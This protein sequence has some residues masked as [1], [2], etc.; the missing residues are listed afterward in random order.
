MWSSLKRTL[1]DF[2][3]GVD[4]AHAVWHG[5]PVKPRRRKHDESAAQAAEAAR[6]ADRRTPRRDIEQ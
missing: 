4:A 5:V 1:R 2:T 6:D 3:W